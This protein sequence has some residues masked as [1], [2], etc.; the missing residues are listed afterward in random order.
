MIDAKETLKK[1]HT[2]FPELTLD[3][4]FKILDCYTYQYRIWHESTT[5]KDLIPN[6]FE[7][8]CSDDTFK[9]YK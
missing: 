2:E 5:T 1:L 9:N 6:S 4:L 8:T 7:V 3:D